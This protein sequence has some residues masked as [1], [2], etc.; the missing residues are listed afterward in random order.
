MKWKASIR[1]IFIN[2]EKRELYLK[3]FN[4]IPEAPADGEQ[5]VRKNRFWR[6]L[7]G[8]IDID[9]EVT[10]HSENAVKSSGIWTFVTGLWDSLSQWVTG[11]FVSQANEDKGSVAKQEHEQEYDH[12]AFLTSVPPIGLE[13]E[14]ENGIVSKV[15]Y[16]DGNELIINRDNGNIIGFEDDNY[17]W[18]INKTNNIITGITVTKK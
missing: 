10:E 4:G 14:R 7:E 18:T 11:T 8:A 16:S 1:K 15:I 9:N 3:V 13:I 5:Y 17:I 2:G 6:K 12:D